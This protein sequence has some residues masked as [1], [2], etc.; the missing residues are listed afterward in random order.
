MD[1]F[2]GAILILVVI[3]LAYYFLGSF[4]SGLCG[5]PIWAAIVILLLISGGK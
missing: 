5:I 3:V 4:L 1:E 2:I